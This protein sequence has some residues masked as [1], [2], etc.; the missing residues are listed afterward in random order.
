MGVVRHAQVCPKWR[1]NTNQKFCNVLS[2]CVNFLGPVGHLWKLK[3]DLVILDGCGQVCQGM[4]KVLRNNQWPISQEFCLEVFVNYS[5]HFSSIWSDMSGHPKVYK[6]NRSAI[7]LS[8]KKYLVTVL[9][10][11]VCN[12]ISMGTINLSCHIYRCVLWYHPFLLDRLCLRL[13]TI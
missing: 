2:E 6:N 13:S 9:V 7:S 10:F 11:F 4:V 8:T 12:S 3:I 1:Y 5:Y